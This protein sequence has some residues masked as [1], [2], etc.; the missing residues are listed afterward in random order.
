MP[1]SPE[2]QAQYDA[3][4]TVVTLKN[5]L[6]VRDHPSIY[7]WTD[8]PLTEHVQSTG[9]ALTATGTAKETIWDEFQGTFY[10]GDT[11]VHGLQVS[12][13]S[14]ACGQVVDRA[15]RWEATVSA[16][17]ESVFNEAFGARKP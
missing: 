13:V 2:A 3:A 8:Y 9:C 17:A 4:L 12:G 11:S 15:M 16:V 14:C 10:D 5:G 6:V 7:M 1:M